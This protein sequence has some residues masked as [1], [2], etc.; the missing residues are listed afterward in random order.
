MK[1]L[2][3]YIIKFMPE[4]EAV[5][6]ELRLSVLD[7]IYELMKSLDVDELSSDDIK[8]KLKLYDISVENMSDAWLPNGRFYRL[9]PSIKHHRTRQNTLKSIAQSGGQFEGLWSNEFMTKPQYNYKYIQL[10]RHYQLGS[11]ADGYFYISGDVERD[12]NGN[13][14]SSAVEALSSD[15]LMSQALPAGYTYLYVPWPRPHYPSD[16]DYFYNVHMLSFDRLQYVEDCSNPLQHQYYREAGWELVYTDP[17]DNSRIYFNSNNHYTNKYYSTKEKKYSGNYQPFDGY[18]Y[19]FIRETEI[20]GEIV[21]CKTDRPFIDIDDRY[22]ASMYYDWYNGIGTPYKT[23]YWFDYHYMN[24]MTH[25]DNVSW[26]IPE[27][28]N[29]YKDTTKEVLLNDNP[30]DATYYELEDS[31]KELGDSNASFGTKC[32]GHYRFETSSPTRDDKCSFTPYEYKTDCFVTLNY[33]S[34]DRNVAILALCNELHIGSGT[35]SAILAHTPIE[36]INHI[37]YNGAT[38]LVSALNSYSDVYFNLSV[39]VVDVYDRVAIK[40]YSCSKADLI[41]A[42][43]SLLSCSNETATYIADHVPYP[44]PILYE[45]PDTESIIAALTDLECEVVTNCKVQCIDDTYSLYEPSAYTLPCGAYVFDYLSPDYIHIS[46]EIISHIK[47][48]RPFWDVGSPVY[49]MMQSDQVS[50]LLPDSPANHSLYYWMNLKQQENVPSVTEDSVYGETF[51]RDNDP[52]VSEVTFT[53]YDRPTVH[54]DPTYVAFGNSDS[55]DQDENC[56]YYN[57]I[58]QNHLYEYGSDTPIKY[59]PTLSYIIFNKYRADFDDDWY[60]ECDDPYVYLEGDPS[61]GELYINGKYTDYDV[62]N[63]ITYRTSPIHKLWLSPNKS[64]VEVSTNTLYNRQGS[65]EIY[66]YSNNTKNFVYNILGVYT[67]SGKRIDST[68][69]SIVC[70]AAG[71]R[72][73]VRLINSGEHVNASYIVFTTEVYDGPSPV[74]QNV[75][76]FN[77]ATGQTYS[78]TLDASTN[79]IT[80][81][82]QTMTQS[83]FYNNNYIIK[84][85]STTMYYGDEALTVYADD[86][87]W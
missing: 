71:S 81:N 12:V 46:P 84:K 54:L 63:H 77:A 26:P 75:S 8:E 34:G 51:V 22:P 76:V 2:P 24:Y 80:F 7:H 1:I 18:I 39:S 37:S 17:T 41:A 50:P 49:A 32:H 66:Y 36:I 47:T 60:E 33:W 52:P 25:V 45:D 11:D 21:S 44:L 15:I 86:M 20:D 40:S 5:L 82:N 69:M 30:E 62:F 72:Y 73:E 31:C 68:N 9:Y 10:M 56:A 79:T 57:D 6:E 3:D 48:Y 35:A 38:H 61:T 16:S 53:S 42:L 4:I 87:I 55:Q 65:D 70:T 74:I 27:H 85:Y 64:D 14:T 67:A 83:D 28:G 58:T 19:D 43:E 13:I 59:D 29:Y 23:P 78:A